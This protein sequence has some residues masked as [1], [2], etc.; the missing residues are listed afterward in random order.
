MR[1]SSP[2]CIWRQGSFTETRWARWD[3]SRELWFGRV[4]VIGVCIMILLAGITTPA[5]AQL[6]GAQRRQLTPR[7]IAQISDE[8]LRVVAP[9]ER[10]LSGVPIASRQLTFDVKRT[11]TAFGAPAV[12]DTAMKLKRRVTPASDSVMSDCSYMDAKPCARLGSGAYISIDPLARTDS[13]A[14]VRANVSWVDRCCSK[15]LIAGRPETANGLL[16]GF[17]TKLHL[18][19]NADGTWT[20]D[21]ELETVAA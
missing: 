7:E 14:V 16:A 8:V 1:N 15:P 10:S 2:S 18:V 20:V 9:P 19:R 11:L 4:A 5:S 3:C 12:S 6:V 21:K 13:D 17:S